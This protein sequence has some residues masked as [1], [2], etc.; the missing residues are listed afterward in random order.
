MRS[1]GLSSK[2]AFVLAALVFV[3]VVA[4]RA[5]TVSLLASDAAAQSDPVDA[6]TRATN[7]DA[8]SPCSQVQIQ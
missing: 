2:I 7:V 6:V 5:T 4:S 3:L 1:V 8:F